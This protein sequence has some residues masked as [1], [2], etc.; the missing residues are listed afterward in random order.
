MR[1]C[2]GCMSARN[3][4]PCLAMLRLTEI[5]LPLDHGEGALK[6]AILLKLDIREHELKDFHIHRRGIDAR[7]PVAISVIYT[8]DVSLADEDTVLSRFASDA[9]VARTQI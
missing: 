2:A 8:V 1:C 9:R 7:K 5:K 3:A 6:S 4:E